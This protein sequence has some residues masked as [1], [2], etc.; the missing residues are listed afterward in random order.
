MS[1]GVDS[2]GYSEK[3][4]LA[5]TRILSNLI[6][7]HKLIKTVY[8]NVTYAKLYS[9]FKIKIGFIVSVKESHFHRE[10]CRVSRSKL[11]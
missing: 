5:Y 2:G 4:L 1:M 8:N 6:K 9:V 11:T 3:Y 10:S 7:S